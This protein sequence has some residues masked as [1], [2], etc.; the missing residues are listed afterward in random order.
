MKKIILYLSMILLL[1]SFAFAATPVFTSPASS[2]TTTNSATQT[3]TITGCD[4][5]YKY[6]IYSSPISPANDTVLAP[7]VVGS[8]DVTVSTDGTYYYNGFCSDGYLPTNISSLKSWFSLD[9]GDT[10]FNISTNSSNDAY[11]AQLNN[12]TNE[13][14]VLKRGLFLCIIN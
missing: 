12:L 3:L 4:A 8:V 6:T 11:V 7:N 14:L 13:K 1:F 2:G 10:E 9:T 5:G